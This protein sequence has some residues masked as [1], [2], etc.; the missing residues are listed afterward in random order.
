VSQGEFLLQNSIILTI[1]CPDRVGIVAAVS[2]F[3]TAHEGFII[4]A[5]QYGDPDSQ[6]FF[7]RIVFRRGDHSPS[8][9]EFRQLFGPI[10]E[11]F[12]MDFQMHDAARK[13]RVAILVSKFGHCLN[14]L[15]H[16]HQSGSLNAE[17]VTVISNHPDMRALV[18]WHGIDYHHLPVTA[19]TKRD[20]EGQIEAILKEKGVELTVL[21]RYMQ[22]LSPELSAVLSGRC[23]NIHHSFL[24]SFKGAKP[25]HQ[26]HARGVKL[27]GATAH[28]VTDALDE[29]PI[30]D[31]EVA[32]VDHTYT[33]D[34]YV[35]IGADIESVVLARALRY[36]TEHRVLLN[37]MKTVVFK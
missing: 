30:I 27:I 5:A 23:I 3:L 33:A 26:A 19:A 12:G 37:G 28:Y 24:P 32:S 35:Q 9:D 29:G 14:D 17:V 31:Q 4:E 34:D 10:A 8:L 16:R 11:R 1:T 21:A 22:V 2:G 36:H 6:R 15:L 18:E 25:Y 13:T 7:Q 20:Q